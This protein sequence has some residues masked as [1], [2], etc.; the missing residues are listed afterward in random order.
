MVVVFSAPRPTGVP[1][2]SGIC[3]GRRGGGRDRREGWRWDVVERGE[4]GERGEMGGGGEGR[5]RGRGE[6]GVEE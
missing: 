2:I 3:S 5:E 6:R 4:R 1:S